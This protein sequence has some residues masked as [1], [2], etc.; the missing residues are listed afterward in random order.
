M[1]RDSRRGINL[2]LAIFGFHGLAILL[3]G[4]SLL[5]FKSFA[6]TWLFI[7]L[8]VSIGYYMFLGFWTKNYVE[9]AEENNTVYVFLAFFGVI[10]IGW[11]IWLLCYSYQ[12]ESSFFKDFHWIFY[13]GYNLPYLLIATTFL[14]ELRSSTSLFLPI[15][16]FLFM[17][18]GYL[19]AKRINRAHS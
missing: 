18:L 13:Y 19:L 16:P 3:S 4:F 11:L 8:V 2:I 10:W 15:F 9:N 5:L 12:D 14:K 1:T 17:S 7:L 6:Q